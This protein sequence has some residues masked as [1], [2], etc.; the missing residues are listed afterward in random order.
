MEIEIIDFMKQRDKGNTGNSI[1][2][3]AILLIIFAILGL[4]LLFTYSGDHADIIAECTPLPGYSCGP[5]VFDHTNGNLVMTLSQHTG[6]DWKGAVFAY[7]PD[8]TPMTS[9]IPDI[10]E[11]E[12]TT[13]YALPNGTTVSLNLK[14]ILNGAALTSVPV[15]T[16][17][18]GKIWACYSK[19]DRVSPASF[20]A[21]TG[22]IYAAIITVNARAE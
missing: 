8:G 11:K 2:V 4:Y 16:P 19:S 5:F 7:V 10:P 12:V 20:N 14:V 6:T 9:G 21:L 15:A 22:C 17:T 13:D 3:F 1:N 18:S